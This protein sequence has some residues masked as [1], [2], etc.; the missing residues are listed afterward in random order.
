[1]KPSLLL[2]AVATVLAGG[3]VFAQTAGGGPGGGTPGATPPPTSAGSNYLSL[4]DLPFTN[5]PGFDTRSRARVCFLGS[6]IAGANR[7]G[8]RIVYVQARG[9]AIFRLEM[10]DGCEALHAAEK[11]TVRVA[12][13]YETCTGDKGLLVVRTAAGSKRC[14]IEAIRHLTATE[15]AALKTSTAR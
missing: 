6:A 13:Q 8:D 7:I 11:L 14:R 9:G 1:M 2:L 12:G 15:L 4:G 3:P 5:V 10:P